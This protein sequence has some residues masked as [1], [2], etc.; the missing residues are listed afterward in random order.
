MN[1]NISTTNPRFFLEAI[2]M[3][4]IQLGA[5]DVIFSF[6]TLNSLDE[7][8]LNFHHPQFKTEIL[9]GSDL[10]Q[11][12][13]PNLVEPLELLSFLL[14]AS[15]A[16]AS[17]HNRTQDGIFFPETFYLYSEGLKVNSQPLQNGLKICI[18]LT[19]G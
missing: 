1:A 2:L 18:N 15:G 16:D 4:G 8:G 14:Y 11:V 13:T 5:S 17:V 10:V 19:R 7:T 9:I 12:P 6:D 3:E